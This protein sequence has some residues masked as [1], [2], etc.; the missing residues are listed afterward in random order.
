MSSPKSLLVHDDQLPAGLTAIP[1]RT[2]LVRPGDDMVALTEQAVCGIARPG[3][4][5]AVAESALAIAQGEF[6]AAEH[7]RPSPLAYAIAR[8]ADPMATI[9]QPESIQLVIDR[10]GASLTDA[11]SG[12]PTC[13]D[14]RPSPLIPQL[15]AHNSPPIVL[16]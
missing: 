13:T 3:D 9:S 8:R 2:R 5:V 11:L 16:P 14:I 10:A 1:V 4:V 15:T 7:V 6:L 12:E